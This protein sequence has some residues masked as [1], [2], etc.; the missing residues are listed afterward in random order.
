MKKI[1]TF[2]FIY[3][4]ILRNKK[5]KHIKMKT[6]IIIT[7]LSLIL[8][9]TLSNCY[10]QAS[11]ETIKQTNEQIINQEEITY[12]MAYNRLNNIK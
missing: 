12:Q 2:R 10:L 8:I 7:L 1:S 9:G 11:Y 5:L 4:F 6:K 3:I